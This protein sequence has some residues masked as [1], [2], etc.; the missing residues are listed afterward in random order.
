MQVL[1]PRSG[2]LVYGIVIIKQYFAILKKI[3]AYDSV[4]KIKLQLSIKNG[5]SYM[6]MI[7]QGKTLILKDEQKMKLLQCR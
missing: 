5:I 6:P 1:C 4:H 7:F 2:L 3:T